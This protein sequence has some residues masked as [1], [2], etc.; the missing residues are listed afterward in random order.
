M[1]SNS[2]IKKSKKSSE[3]KLQKPLPEQSE[4]FEFVGEIVCWSVNC[5]SNH[6]T[7]VEELKNAGLDESAA[8]EI[9]VKASF[10]RATKKLSDDGL[11]DIV[12]RPSKDEISFQLT[13]KCI[14]QSFSNET[15]QE[16][17][18][19]REC[20]LRLNTETGKVTCSSFPDLEERIQ[21][22]VNDCM[23]ERTTSDISTIIRRLFELEKV[24]LFPIKEGAAGV[25]FVI[26][27]SKQL[28]DKINNFTKN[29]NAN[30]VRWPIP[31]GVDS[32]K[33][34]EES[35]NIGI[36]QMIDS[37]L[38]EID[39]LEVRT[40]PETIE[41][42]LK[43]IEETEFKLKAYSHFLITKEKELNNALEEAKKKYKQKLNEICGIRETAKICEIN[44][45]SK[46]V[47]IFTH[48]MGKMIK[49]LR[50]QREWKL[51]KVS[52]LLK[53]LFG[54]RINTATVVTTYSASQ[55]AKEIIQIT[56]E[57]YEKLDEIACNE[58]ETPIFDQM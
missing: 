36:N 30:L 24:D 32:S 12:G 46:R 43:S 9:S 42:Q 3:K 54:E 35:I 21:K 57:Q 4:K 44:T 11:F 23:E 48:S 20:F 14:Q 16:I 33:A 7:I 39:K 51:E 53:N 45:E 19:R 1:S 15:D 34:I 22:L 31:K 18:Y 47:A 29:I 26:Q 56:D 37:H 10:T 55:D 38:T 13:K 8:K 50:R 41:N 58:Y 27:S 6:K 40:R 17:V 25:Y 5:P 52:K 2:T 28:V 49:H